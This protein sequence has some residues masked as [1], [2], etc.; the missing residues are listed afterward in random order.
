MS[1]LQQ[2]REQRGEPVTLPTGLEV[3]VQQFNLLDVAMEGEIPAPLVTL[4]GE[5]L[6]GKDVS[7]DV[8]DFQKIGPLLNQV[9]KKAIID[10]PVADEPDDTHL[11]LS[12]LT[13]MDKFFVFEKVNDISGVT[14]LASFRQEQDEPVDDAQPGEHVRDEAITDTGNS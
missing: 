12:E 9:A 13:A 3:R 11:G 5:L 8:E 4:V 6:E 1:K 2:W 7:V 14:G 10:P